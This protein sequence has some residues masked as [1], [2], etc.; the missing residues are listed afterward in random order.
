[1][2]R[3]FKA[4]FVSF[5]VAA[6][7][8]A[9]A[10]HAT[11]GYFKIGYGTKNRG[12]AGAGMAFG[13]DATAAA[14]NPA[15]IAQVGNNIVGGVE[16]FNP[17]RDGELDATGLGGAREQETSGATLF[18]IPHFGV[19]RVLSDRMTVG[20]SFTANGGMNTRFNNNIFNTALGPAIGQT[21]S[22]GTPSGFA[23]FLEGQGIPTSTIDP[24]LVGFA[25]DSSAQPDATLGVN[26]AQAILAPTLAY[27]VVEGHTF[28][29]SALLAYQ[30]FRA[31]GLGLFKGLSSD[32]GS[33]TDQG[34]DHSFGA[35]VR[36]GWTSR[37]TDSLTIGG[38]Y[39]SKIY[40]DKFDDYAGLFAN[41]GEFDIPAQYGVGIA[42]Q[43]SDRTTLALDVQR[44]LYS[45][46]DAI[47]NPG[48][49]ANE[50]FSAFNAVLSGGLAGSVS[51]PLGSN[52]G[53]G[54]GWDN[55]TVAK[56]GINHR[57]NEKW[58]FR[59]GVNYGENPIDSKENFF[60]IL[61]PGVVKWHLTAGFSYSPKRNQDVSVTFM[62]ALNQEQDFNFEGT[63][64]FAGFSHDTEIGMYQNAIEVSY[65]MNF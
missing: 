40:M 45:D 22:F 53:F 36:V 34:N 10:A 7:L 39:S 65:S 61:A 57:Y 50:T 4:S 18:A 35:G 56:V 5:A 32:P 59:G 2:V 47:G 26:L 23:G 55:I 16:I 6:A 11:N 30:Q 44:I 14:S 27:E 38:Q 3:T 28:G 15:T 41:E 20:L 43:P 33:V 37:L 8:A 64:P 21:S 42:W 54:F 62:H 25:T 52:D 24:V 1:M 19:S 48:P 9:P 17:E 13:Q 31:H 29:V 60:N 46:V 49:T 12:M 63:G 58:T 51:N